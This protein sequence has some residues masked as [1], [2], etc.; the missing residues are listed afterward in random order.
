TRIMSRH[1]MNN[2]NIL[3]V[4]LGRLTQANITASSGKNG[5]SCAKLSQLRPF[6]YTHAFLRD[7]FKRI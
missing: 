6:S 3:T 1:I 5:L 7:L 2:I 4:I